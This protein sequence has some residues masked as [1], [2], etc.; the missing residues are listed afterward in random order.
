MHGRRDHP[1]TVNPVGLDLKLANKAPKTAQSR[2]SPG[3]VFFAPA[4]QIQRIRG[5]IQGA[6]GPAL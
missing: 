5:F 2:D 3:A 1:F 6:L 4:D